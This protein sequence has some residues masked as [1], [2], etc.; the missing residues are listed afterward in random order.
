MIWPTQAKKPY[1]AFLAKLKEGGRPHRDIIAEIIG[2]AVGG[3]MI[4][5]QAVAQIVDFYMDDERAA[6]RAE[7]VGLANAD[8]QDPEQKKLLLGYVREAQRALLFCYHCLVVCTERVW[9]CRAAPGVCCAH[10]CR[11][12]GGH[13]P[14]RERQT[15]RVCP[16]RRHRLQQ[17]QERASQRTRSPSH[18][19]II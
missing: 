2:L 12:G 5:A 17:L 4:Y 9:G 3:G 13:D 6:E 19:P 11:G 8:S 1:H 15:V 7:I 14:P 16:T 10:P 18:S